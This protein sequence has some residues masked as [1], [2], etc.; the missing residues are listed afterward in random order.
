MLGRCYL[1]ATIVEPNRGEW[2]VTQVRKMSART[3]W[4]VPAAAVAVVGVTI[5]ASAVAN[6]AGPSLPAQSVTQLLADVQQASAKSQGPVT[7][8]IQETANLG[9]P[10]LP[11]IGA[12]TGQNGQ[13]G[14]LNLLAGTTTVSIWYLNQNHVRIAQEMQ[15]GESDL[16]LDGTQLWL[17]DSKTQTATHVLLPKS[18]GNEAG[19][20]QQASSIPGG[21]AGL[22]ESPQAAARQALAQ[23]GPSTNVRLGPNVTVAGRAAYQISL[24]PKASGSLVSQVLIAI[25]AARHIPLR[26]EVIARD[27]SSPAF[28]VGYTALAFGPPAMSNFSFTPPPGAH[29]K[30]E[31]IPN[32]PAGLKG[33]LGAHLG[34]GE[35]GLGALGSGVTGLGP[36]TAVGVHATRISCGKNTATCVMTTPPPAPAAPAIP[37]SALKQIEAQFAA[38]LPKNLSKAKRAAEIKSFEQS[39]TAGMQAS[40]GNGG[41]VNAQ[42]AGAPKVVGKDWTS[43]LVTP[44]NPEVAA[45]VQ[46]LLATPRGRHTSFGIL[47]GSSS[48]VAATPDGADGPISSGPIP[49]GPDLAVLRTL[50]QAS[51]PVHGSWGSGRLLRSALLSVLV[52]SKG[53]ILAGAVTPSVLYADAASQSK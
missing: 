19:A 23:L 11:Q 36:S 43:V 21:V 4:A 10:A 32:S 33:N 46:Q 6:A 45:M 29:V 41:F 15:M 40:P 8:T 47:G 5:G 48:Q 18:V 12:I 14:S 22:N 34:L 30:T 16:R 35:L 28:E 7:A 44:A 24:S 25:D 37:K 52:T 42:A 3:R 26:V 27:S 53:Q 20:G 1:R 51:T 13:L 38:H 39:I 2:R 31:T 17:W 50:L 9:L 49:V